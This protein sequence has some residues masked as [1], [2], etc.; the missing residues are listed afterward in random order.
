[1][2]DVTRTR[3]TT[4]TVANVDV[5]H[6]QSSQPNGGAAAAVASG[7]ERDKSSRSLTADGAETNHSQST[8]LNIRM[9]LK[10]TDHR[11]PSQRDEDLNASSKR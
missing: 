11:R 7:D 10:P 6:S 8:L 9:A 4:V 5:D 1:M 3:N 2:S